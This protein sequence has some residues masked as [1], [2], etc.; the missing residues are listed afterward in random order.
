M[1]SVRRAVPMYDEMPRTSW[2]FKY[3]AQNTVVVSRTFFTQEVN[4]A[5]DELEEGNEDALKTE[6]ERQVATNTLEAAG[7][8]AGCSHM[9]SSRSFHQTLV[10]SFEQQQGTGFD[11]RQLLLF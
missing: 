6:Y 11:M 1:M 8:I 10:N 2:I 4:E 7:C 3:S 5:F 9:L